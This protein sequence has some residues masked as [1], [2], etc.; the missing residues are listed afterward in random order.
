MGY[1]MAESDNKATLKADDI[2][3]EIKAIADI[4]QV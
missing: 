3:A 1:I 2:S 4:K